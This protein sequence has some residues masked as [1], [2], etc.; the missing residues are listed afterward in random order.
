MKYYKIKYP[1]GTLILPESTVDNMFEKV[2]VEFENFGDVFPVE[3]IEIF[4]SSLGME[5]VPLLERLLSLPSEQLWENFLKYTGAIMI[6]GEVF[7]IQ[8]HEFSFSNSFFSSDSILWE[9]EI[10]NMKIQGKK[11]KICPQGYVL[12]YRD[13]KKDETVERT[14]S[15]WVD[16]KEF[17]ELKEELGEKF[18]E[19]VQ[20]IIKVWK[21]MIRNKEGAINKMLLM[22]MLR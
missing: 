11:D 12:S 8:F 22:G 2:T 15:G 10:G 6:V 20:K 14:L 21:N 17:E 18:D 1:N 3:K 9:H 16:Y 4:R 7:R 19:H 13:E 5:L